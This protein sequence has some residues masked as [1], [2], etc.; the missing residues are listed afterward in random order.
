MRKDKLNHN[1]ENYRTAMPVLLVALFGMIAYLYIN[2][3]T[4]SVIKIIIL[5]AGILIVS[6]VFGLYTWKNIKDLNE[7]EEMD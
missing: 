4:L 5:G 6:I 7:L 2:A 1:A 3:G